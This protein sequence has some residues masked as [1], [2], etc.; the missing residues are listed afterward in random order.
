MFISLRAGVRVRSAFVNEQN[1]N[2]HS[3]FLHRTLVPSFFL[4]SGAIAGALPAGGN[5]GHSRRRNRPNKKRRAQ[6]TRAIANGVGTS[7]RGDER[8]GGQA[9]GQVQGLPPGTPL[10]GQDARGSQAQSAY[11]RDG[12]ARR[13]GQAR[14]L[15]PTAELAASAWNVIGGA[16][17]EQAPPETVLLGKK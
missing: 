9:D 6:Q 4:L 2:A 5:V 1:L 14:L 8:R 3:L 13:V 12:Q 15:S 7:G 17:D 10:D 11:M 16:G